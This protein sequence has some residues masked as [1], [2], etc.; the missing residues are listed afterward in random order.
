MREGPASREADAQGD[1]PCR[2]KYPVKTVDCADIRPE[3]FEENPRDPGND[4]YDS[5]GAAQSPLREERRDYEYS[6]G[7]ENTH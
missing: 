7:G 1:G 6:Q 2:E 3:G 5:R 4:A